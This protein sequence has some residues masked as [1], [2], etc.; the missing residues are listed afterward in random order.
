MAELTKDYFDGQFDKL[1]QAIARGFEETATKIELNKVE[2]EL[3]G[4]KTSITKLDNRLGVVEINL[5]K[6]LHTEYV[7]LEVRVKRLEQHTGL[8]TA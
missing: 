4:V 3:E 1:G 5:N 7:H 8:K 6:A 2:V